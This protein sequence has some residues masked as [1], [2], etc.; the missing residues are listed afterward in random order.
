MKNSK[1]FALILTLTGLLAGSQAQTQSDAKKSSA[2]KPAG[3]TAQL[4][5]PSAKQAA[6][7]PTAP[8]AKSRN[9]N[10]TDMYMMRQA[11]AGKQNDPQPQPASP[12]PAA[13]TETS[14]GPRQSVSLDGASATPTTPPDS[15]AINANPGPHHRPGTSAATKSKPPAPTAAPSQPAT[16]ESAH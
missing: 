2:P 4:S 12:V 6:G 7:T 14:R 5:D 11:G 16:P 9:T 8:A 10:L 13:A 3:S 15:R 1:H